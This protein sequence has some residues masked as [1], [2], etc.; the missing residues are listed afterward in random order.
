MTHVQQQSTTS[1]IRLQVDV[2]NER[3]RNKILLIARS[4]GLL[5]GLS[6]DE[7][8]KLRDVLEIGCGPGTWVLEVVKHHADVKAFG[9]D[10]RK[11]AIL[12]AQA[13]V[14]RLQVHNVQFHAVPDMSGP[15]PYPDQSFDLISMQN[16]SLFLYRQSWPQFLAE[17]FRLLRPG[18]KIRLTEFE[19]G[20]SNAPAHEEFLSLFL[21][22]M[23]QGGRSL[24]SSGRHLG[25]F[26]QMQSLLMQAGFRHI[27]VV[28]QS[29]NYSTTAP[30]ETYNYEWQKDYL[31]L[32]RGAMSYIVKMGLT[33]QEQG[34]MLLRRQ[35]EEMKY[36]WF[37]AVLP[38]KTFWGTKKP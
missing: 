7:R 24:S 19:M 18:G 5:P 20:M 17:C 22:A 36:P 31:L 14:K 37:C 25:T 23:A 26:S 9:V 33:T 32:A 29:I 2:E 3:L 8:D 6:D 10:T 30:P 35:E 13:T 34:E 16:I 28:E 38:F 21:Q 15:F 12:Y 11:Q 4:L 1:A 27:S